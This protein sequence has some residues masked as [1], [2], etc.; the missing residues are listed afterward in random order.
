[1]AHEK[2]GMKLANDLQHI[3]SETNTVVEMTR[4]WLSGGTTTLQQH[5]LVLISEKKSRNNAPTARM[6]IISYNESDFVSYF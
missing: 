2:Y 1:M 6:N 5:A 4:V 3:L